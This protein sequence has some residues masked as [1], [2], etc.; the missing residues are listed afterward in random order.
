MERGN[1]RLIAT[2]VLPGSR[3]SGDQRVPG[4][5]KNEFSFLRKEFLDG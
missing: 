4:Q 5:T 2:M 3:F 1:K